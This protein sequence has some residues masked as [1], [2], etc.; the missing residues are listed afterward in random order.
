MIGLLLV[1]MLQ[2]EPTAADT[3]DRAKL[4]EIYQRPQFERARRRNDGGLQRLW[5]N[6]VTWFE[7]AFGSRG[8]ETY[9]VVA[10][11][12]VL[13]AAALV[14]LWAVL[15]MLG[16]KRASPMLTPR[17]GTAPLVLDDPTTHLGRGRALLGSDP[18]A[19]LREGLLA[20]L[21][22]LE[23]RKLARPDRVKTNK[24]LA[25][26]LPG[27]GA[28]APLTARVEQLVA[29]YDRTFYSLEPVGTQDAARF[30]D[31]IERLP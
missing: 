14:A 19:A 13:L 20:L 18:R 25:G 30:L 4:E 16:R 27:R 21:S 7:R 6:F 23:R 12:L 8:A 10:R 9:S 22:T 24:E 5:R 3:V 17:P 11:F 31:D 28:A 26:E 15:K 29:W 1:G 2:A